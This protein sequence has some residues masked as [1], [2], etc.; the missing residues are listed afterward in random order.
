VLEQLMVFALAVV[1]GLLAGL[2]MPRPPAPREAP[3]ARL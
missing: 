1:V 3:E 2:G